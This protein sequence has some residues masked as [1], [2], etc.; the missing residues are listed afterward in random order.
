MT[1]HDALVAAI[2]AD[3]D[4]DT[5]RLA[6]ADFLQENGEPERAEFVRA[7]IDLARTPAWEPFAVLCKWRRLDWFAGI[8]FRSA[9]P[10]VDGFQL[11]WHPQAFRRGLGSRLN[12]RSLVAWDQVSPE[13]LDRAPL[14]ELHLWAATLDDWQRFAESPVLPRLRKLH[15]VNSPIEPLRVLR[16]VPEVLGITDLYF[17][18]AS[19]AG[20]PVV[21]EELLQSRLGNAV[22]GLHFHMGYQSL[23]DLV[24]AIGP[25]YELQRLSLRTMG[26]TEPLVGRLMSLGVARNLTQLDMSGSPLGGDGL[27]LLA[28]GLPLSVESLQLSGTGAVG[29]GLRAIVFT[30]R[31]VNLRHLDLSQ[32]PLAPRETKM[33]SESRPLSRLRSVTL[34]QCRIGDKG[35]RHITRAKFWRNLVELDLRDNPISVGGIRHLLDAPVPPD[36]TALVLSINQLGNASRSELRRKYGEAVVFAADA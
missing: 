10:P 9:L 4:E 21:I 35:M 12:V 29:N 15:F 33:L 13:L 17:D 14:G 31:V 26:L 34:R 28:N 8:P 20:M 16:D 30:S 7:Q 23:D 27:E 24:D 36:L 1:D 19:G 2:C 3:P 32:N 22:R 18:R 25:A 11:E 6:Y 5:P